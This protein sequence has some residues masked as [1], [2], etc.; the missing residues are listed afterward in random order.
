M[1]D[2]VTG[3]HELR[4]H[5]DSRLIELTLAGNKRAYEALVL[6]Y[7]KI[8]YNVIYHLV[9]QNEAAADVTQETFI[10]A[11]QALS[12]FRIGC[13]VKPW[14]LRIAT[15]SALNWLRGQKVYQSLDQMLAEEPGAEPVSNDNVEQGVEFKLAGETLEKILG[16]LSAEH[17][18]LFVLRH[19]YDLS[20]EEMAEVMNQPITTIKS[21]LFRA[22]TKIRELMK[23]H[24]VGSML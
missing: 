23:K 4:N 5:E 16:H 18:H 19:Q 1:R 8:V 12:R 21:A 13:A 3:L 24:S 15:N 2:Q 22:R 6:R 14:L 11:Y 9:R 10:K 20:Y 17:R 7:Q